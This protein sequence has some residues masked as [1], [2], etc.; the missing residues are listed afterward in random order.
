MISS[1]MEARPRTGRTKTT[2]VTTFVGV[3]RRFFEEIREMKVMG[4]DK[5]DAIATKE[6][7]SSLTGSDREEEL[8]QIDR[9]RLL[10]GQAREGDTLLALQEW[11]NQQKP[12]YSGKAVVPNAIVVIKNDDGSIEGYWITPSTVSVEIQLQW[13]GRLIPVM[14]I[15]LSSPFGECLLGRKVDDTVVCSKTYPTRRVTVEAIG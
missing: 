1:A 14:A 11:V 5:E 12:Y 8:R 3:R 15:S 9:D 13:H 7:I 4:M 6:T 10:K 2:T